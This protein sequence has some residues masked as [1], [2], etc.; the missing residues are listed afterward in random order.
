MEK[1]KQGGEDSPKPRAEEFYGLIYRGL[2]RVSG[3]VSHLLTEEK[4]A[5]VVPEGE[6]SDGRGSRKVSAL[7]E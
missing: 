7:S 2:P 4:M 3:R 6:T 1:D 5:I